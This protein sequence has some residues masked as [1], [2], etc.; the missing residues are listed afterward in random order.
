VRPVAEIIEECAQ[1]CLDTLA[2][3]GRQYVNAPT[4]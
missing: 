4:P 1:G 2:A 3:L